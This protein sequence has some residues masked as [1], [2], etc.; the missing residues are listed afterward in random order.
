[1]P[2]NI[3]GRHCGKCLVPA[4]WGWGTTGFG[5]LTESG[6]LATAKFVL[7]GSRIAKSFHLEKPAKIIEP[8]HPQPW[9]QGHY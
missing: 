5:S 3:W 1:M 9:N 8:S 2:E 6:S 7:W 4:V